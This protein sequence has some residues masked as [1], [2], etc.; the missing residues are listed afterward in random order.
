MASKEFDPPQGRMGGRSKHTGE[1]GCGGAHRVFSPMLFLTELPPDIAGWAG[2]EPATVGSDNRRTST[3]PSPV[4]SA[5]PVGPGTRTD[6]GTTTGLHLFERD[7]RWSSTRAR[8]G[9]DALI[10]R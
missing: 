4:L 5:R 3:R 6:V 9:P 7:N 1:G 8:T 2:F 10:R